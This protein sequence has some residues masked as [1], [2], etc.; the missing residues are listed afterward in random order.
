M[1]RSTLFLAAAALLLAPATHA[2]TRDASAPRVS[3]NAR[4]TQTFGFTDIDVTYGRP[5][6]RDRVLFADGEAL[7]PYGQVWRAGANEATTV[8]FSTDVEVEGQPLAAGTYALFTIPGPQSWTVLFN[9]QADQWGSMGYDEAQDALRV[10]VTP[11]TAAEPVE[12]MRFTIDDATDEGA[13]I[14]LEWGDVRVPIQV[15]ADFAGVLVDKGNQ[16]NTWQSATSYAMLASQHSL[17]P[18]ITMSWI[19]RAV[20]FESNFYTHRAHAMILA[21]Y[22]DY[23]GAVAAADRA[24]A[25]AQASGDVSARNVD[26]LAATRA[27]WM[28]A[29]NN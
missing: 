22:A 28:S 11:H 10:S 25:A 29:L 4:I 16:A 18:E 12:Q 20:A 23:E 15:T 14:S 26:R 1:L 13:T 27:E 5:S 8:T 9:R 6:A 19:E 17:D 3:P 21:N 24:L 7:A 2:Q